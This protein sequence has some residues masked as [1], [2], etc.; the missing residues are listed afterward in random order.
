MNTVH[1]IGMFPGKKLIFRFFCVF[2][3]SDACRFK[4]PV[5]ETLKK[6]SFIFE[7]APHETLSLTMFRKR[8]LSRLPLALKPHREA[9]DVVC[10]LIHGYPEGVRWSVIANLYKTWANSSIPFNF[11]IF[12][13]FSMFK[14]VVPDDTD[15][16]IQSDPTRPCDFISALDPSLKEEKI[17]SIELLLTRFSLVLS[18]GP[19]LSL[20]QLKLE[21]YRAN[22]QL[23]LPTTPY[24]YIREEIEKRNHR[25]V[26]TIGDKDSKNHEEQNIMISKVSDTVLFHVT[27]IWLDCILVMSQQLNQ[28]SW[29]WEQ[30]QKSLKEVFGIVLPLSP[31][32][33]L[34]LITDHYTIF[35]LHEDH[36]GFRLQQS[37]STQLRFGEFTS[38]KHALTLQ[39]IE[40]LLGS[41]TKTIQ[42]LQTEY[43][44]SI[45]LA[46]VH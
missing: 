3:F 42:Q 26:V 14:I 30:L 44:V 21:Y 1:I 35:K 2:T 15:P 22:R 39:R 9:M 31:R 19:S 25:F 20:Y 5:I 41:D 32:E 11:E 24:P 45:S 46:L 27:S 38:Q 28:E 34:K 43:Q 40:S 6:H 4:G 16:L 36:S 37:S 7:C 23:P 33:I 8:F 13:P 10:Y 29:T 18:S 12:R 17:V